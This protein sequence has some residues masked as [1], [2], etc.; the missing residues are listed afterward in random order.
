MLQSLLLACALGAAPAS[1]EL[2]AL[3]ARDVVTSVGF[4]ETMGL[5]AVR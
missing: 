4:E 2:S 5:F 3:A 1:P